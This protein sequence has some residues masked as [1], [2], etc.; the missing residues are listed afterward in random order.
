MT[1]TSKQSN[2][3]E[4]TTVE[5]CFVVPPEIYTNLQK[6]FDSGCDIVMANTPGGETPLLR[7][8][9]KKI[10]T[11]AGTQVLPMNVTEFMSRP[12]VNRLEANVQSE[13][14]KNNGTPPARIFD[15]DEKTGEITGAFGTDVS[16]LLKKPKGKTS[17]CLKCKKQANKKCSRCGCAAYCSS[18]CQNADWPQHKL[19]CKDIQIARAVIDKMSSPEEPIEK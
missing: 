8:K 7:D 12:P 18:E 1:E 19:M 2:T 15:R 4:D 17:V 13:I 6:Q 14:R 5:P 10:R 9:D 11:I 16:R 3:Q